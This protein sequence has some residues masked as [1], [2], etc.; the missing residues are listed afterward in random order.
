MKHLHEF[1]PMPSSPLEPA[2]QRLYL[3]QQDP[4]PRMQDAPCV[5]LHVR[6]VVKYGP[7]W[8]AW[9]SCGF[10]STSCLTAEEAHRRP[11]EIEEILIS[12]RE[13]ERR[14]YARH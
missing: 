8:Y 12:S 10:V 13:R 9:C 3:A 5:E 7:D 11:C 1:Q 4:Q 14:I 2:D 6:S